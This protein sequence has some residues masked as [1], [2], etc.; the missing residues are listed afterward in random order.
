MKERISETEL[1]VRYFEVAKREFMKIDIE[2]L[3]NTKGVGSKTLEKIIKQHEI[4]N[5]IKSFESIYI[6]SEDYKVDNDINLW[7]G[8]CLKLM[9]H[10][11][12]K[13]VDMILA[14][15][16][17]GITA[18]KWD[19]IIP[20]KPLW[21][22]YERV[23]KDNG[24]IVLF[25]NE[26]FSTQLRASNLDMYRY[27]WIWYKNRPSGFATAKI[28]PMQNHENITV[29]YKNA[30]K[31]YGIKEKREIKSLKNTTSSLVRHGNYGSSTTGFED[32]VG[33]K[34]YGAM[35]NPTTVKK[36]DVVSN[37]KG[38]RL[39]PTQKPVELLE[40]LIKTYTNENEIVL[41][42]VMGSGSTGVACINLNRNFIGMELDED[43]FKIAKERIENHKET[44]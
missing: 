36:F 42:N 17:Y 35:R 39:H 33:K 3:R 6:P 19:S 28:R 4:D 2:T 25:G 29:F 1:N 18:C 37:H 44:E 31:F 40:Y 26:P 41:D 16:P 34:E 32:S 38:N 7:Q 12:D 21:E 27:D 14:D 22:Q 15:L 5:D 8:D 43:Y 10:I 30:P 23:I 13:S 11:P 9:S 24:A 20:F